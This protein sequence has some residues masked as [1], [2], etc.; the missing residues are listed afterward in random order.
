[1]DTLPKLS[2]LTPDERVWRLDW[3]GECAYPGNV[4]RYAQPS[5][6]VVLSPLRSDPADHAALILPD[7]SDHQHP[8]EAWAPVSALPLLTI[9]DLWKQGRQIASPDYQMET[10]KSLSINPESVCFVKAGLAIDEHF[11]LPLNHHPWHRTQTQSYCVVVALEGGRRLL[12][13][14]AEIIRFYFGSSG[15]FLQRL[16]TAPLTSNSLWIDKHFNPANRHLHLIL[17]DRLSGVSAA[18]IGRIAR[19]KFA[20]RAAAG[21]F[22]SCQKASAQQHPAYPYTGF[23]FEGKTD[24]ATSGIWLPFGERENGT[25]LAYR[26][27]S[28]SYPFP[29]QSL[30]YEA[31]DQKAW[32]GAPEK[33]ERGQSKFSPKRP[34]LS[35]VA[36]TDPAAHKQSRTANFTSRHHFPDLVRKQ[37]WREKIEA[38]AKADVFLRRADGH[39]E[40]VA[41]GESNSNSNAAGL[42]VTTEGNCETKPLNEELL[43]RFVRIGLKAIMDNPR[44]APPGAVVKVVCATGKVKPVFNLPM[45]VSEDGEIDRNLL[46]TLAGGGTR[47]RRGCFVDVLDHA[48]H[49]RYLVIAEGKSMREQSA[50]VAIDKLELPAA[51]LAIAQVANLL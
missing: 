4:R 13:P 31:S 12:V 51:L 19:S 38:I 6:K 18:N 50:V 42:D 44:H 49:Q 29:F 41:F 43:P 8:H 48:V 16:F 34:K 15:N 35:E 36:E 11:L 46:V 25:F 2:N 45:L 14:C 39:L 5:I 3:F 22:A 23:P 47:Q 7:S 9:G 21:I 27:R 24:L 10:F 20:W 17:A 30:S 33:H 32:H 40:Q 1:M 28:C 26:L 37:V